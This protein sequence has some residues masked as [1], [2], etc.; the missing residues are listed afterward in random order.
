MATQLEVVRMIAP[1]FAYKTDQEVLAFL[2]LAPLY[3]DPMLYHEDKRGLAIALQACSLMLL[4]QSSAS[5][6]SGGAVVSEREGDLSRSYATGRNGDPVDI[7]RS[8]L[9]SLVCIASMPIMTRI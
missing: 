1:E 9:N 6:A 4:A 2:D 8:Q 3:I 5:G 7:Y